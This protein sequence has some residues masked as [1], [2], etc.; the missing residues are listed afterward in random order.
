MSRSDFHEKMHSEHIGGVDSE[1][2]DQWC[3]SSCF[4]SFYST[5]TGYIMTNQACTPKLEIKH[6]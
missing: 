1:D 2:I 6:P 4:K 3:S 5:L